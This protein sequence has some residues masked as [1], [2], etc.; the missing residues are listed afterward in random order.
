MKLRSVALVLIVGIAATAPGVAAAQTY[1]PDSTDAGQPDASAMP[2]PR[3]EVD[4]VQTSAEDAR[5]PGETEEF[6]VNDGFGD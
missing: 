2:R 3:V 1:T 4:G 5:L 6:I